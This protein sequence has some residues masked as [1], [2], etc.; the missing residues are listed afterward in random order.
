MFNPAGFGLS[1]CSLRGEVARVQT[2]RSSGTFMASAIFFRTTRA[3]RAAHFYRWR[4]DLQISSNKRKLLQIVGA[5][6]TPTFMALHVPVEEPSTA[7][8]ADIEHRA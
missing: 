1:L 5:L 7:S 6:T 4:Y 2:R 8:I 3:K